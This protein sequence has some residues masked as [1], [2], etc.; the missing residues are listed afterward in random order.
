[1]IRNNHLANISG[2]AIYLVEER[3]SN[4][5]AS[6][7]NTYYAD[8]GPVFFLGRTKLTLEELRTELDV[9][10]DSAVKPTWDFRK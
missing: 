9:E 7:G 4:R 10:K 5:L 2:D 3:A 8:G 6:N 1:M